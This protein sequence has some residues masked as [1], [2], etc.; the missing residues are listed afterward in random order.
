[1]TRCVL[2]VLAAGGGTRFAGSGHKL[3]QP[4]GRASSPTASTT[5][6]RAA[7]DAA[8]AAEA[9]PVVLVSGAAAFPAD[10]IPSS[11]E[12]VHHLAWAGGMSGSIRAGLAA[13]ERHRPFAVVL[14]LA[15]QPGVGPEAW[16]AVAGAPDQLGQPIA[17]ARYG[18]RRGPH[19]V[20]LRRDVWPLLPE[21]GDEG[22]RHLLVEHPTWVAEVDCVGSPGD[23]DTVED[24][25]R[26]RS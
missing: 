4:I 2:V 9:G 16:S 21:F 7:V 8:L 12:V 26:W 24:L 18:D 19:P 15:D 17:V 25:A 20:R 22:A 10:E 13:A 11:V 3:H 6:W 1:M 14:G 5:L 23:I